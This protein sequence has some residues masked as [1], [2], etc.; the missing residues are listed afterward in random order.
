MIRLNNQRSFR[1]YQSRASQLCTHSAYIVSMK[2]QLPVEVKLLCN[3]RFSR[4]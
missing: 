3:F 1:S 2:S 4:D